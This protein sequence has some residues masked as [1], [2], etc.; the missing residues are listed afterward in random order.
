[1][2]PISYFLFWGSIHLYLLNDISFG[3]TISSRLWGRILSI[4]HRIVLA[5]PLFSFLICYVS[6]LTSMHGYPY[7]SLQAWF[8]CLRVALL[9]CSC[10]TSHRS[11]I[12]WAC[13]P[14]INSADA[15]ADAGFFEAAR[16]SCQVLLFW[17]LLFQCWR[18][19]F[20]IS[21]DG[22]YLR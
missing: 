20:M 6:S 13:H 5:A 3:I 22:F 8:E 15:L 9:T 14:Y 2:F 7:R 1:M 12:P 18:R 4:K 19:V 11:L 16:E 10:I 21:N 17:L